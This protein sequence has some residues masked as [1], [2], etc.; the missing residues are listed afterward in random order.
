MILSITEYKNKLASLI[1]HSD[2]SKWISGDDAQ[3]LLSQIANDQLIIGVIGQMNVGKSSL[4]NALVFG[5]EVLPTSE[6]P[7]TAALTYISYGDSSSATVEMLSESDYNQILEKAQFDITEDNKTEV[8][9]AKSIIEKI[10]VIS[11][12]NSLFGSKI[13]IPFEDYEEY[14]GA[15]G[16]YTP[17]VKYLRLTINNPQLKGICIVDTPGYND[18]VASRD[19]TTKSFLSQANVIIMVQDV[20]GYFT[21]TDVDIIKDQIPN[22]GVGKLIVALNKSDSISKQE[23]ETV[24]IS[25]NEHKN[26]LAT[27]NPDISCLLEE[28]KIIPISSV[29]SLISQLPDDEVNQNDVLSFWKSEIEYNCPELDSR[30]YLVASGIPSLQSE[31]SDMVLRQKKDILLKAP[32]EKLQALLQA[33]FN[34]MIVERDALE[35]TNQYLSDQQLDFESVLEDLNS[36]ELQVTQLLSDTVS[37]CEEESL[38]KIETTRFNLRDQRDRAIKNINFSEKQSKKYLRTC[39]N[40]VEDVYFRLNISFS[41]TLRLLGNDISDFM[42]GEIS[43]LESRMNHIVLTNAQLIHTSVIKRI[44]KT[45]NGLIPRTIGG[46]KEMKASF[47]DYWE[48]QD[49]Y[50]I[51]IRSFFRTMIQESFSNNYINSITSVYKDATTKLLDVIEKEITSIIIDTKSQYTTD[52]AVSIEQ[53]IVENNKRIMKIDSIL[54]TINSFKTEISSLLN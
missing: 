38:S 47:P 44:N 6:T 7:M 18:P 53:R 51:G 15:N 26:K 48:R 8:Q 4:I 2:E 24:V 19:L 30:D 1:R 27:D 42:H 23:L 37:S 52:E 43:S 32:C 5:K 10:E 16:K 41:D 20:M 45:I 40:E 3:V 22:S 54:P 9:A 49:L 39:F 46:E 28:C 25:A 12:K 21:K 14:V 34:R 33:S 11:D 50:Q 35:E 17:L 36:F 31:I 29:M 13:Q